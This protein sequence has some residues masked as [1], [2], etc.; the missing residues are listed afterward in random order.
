MNFYIY[1]KQFQVYPPCGI[2]CLK[3]LYFVIH[4]CA[5][6]KPLILR[7][8]ATLISFCPLR[9]TKYSETPTSIKTRYRCIAI[10]CWRSQCTNFANL[11]KK[12]LLNTRWLFYIV[13]NG[14]TKRNDGFVQAFKQCFMVAGTH[15]I[16]DVR[17]K[18]FLWWD[19]PHFS[20]LEWRFPCIG[21]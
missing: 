1:S 14:T 15:S 6:R 7:Y 13:L 19:F 11:R 9:S 21:F 2:S 16:K 18:I 12:T 10:W 3:S 17:A 20:L 5:L 4:A 8:S